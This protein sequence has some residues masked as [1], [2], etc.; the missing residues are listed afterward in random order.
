MRMTYSTRKYKEPPS[1]SLQDDDKPERKGE[2]EHTKITSK[3]RQEP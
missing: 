2:G 1:H 3:K